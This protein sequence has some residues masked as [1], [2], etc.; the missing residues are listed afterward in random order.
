MRMIPARLRAA[1]RLKDVIDEAVTRAVNHHNNMLR[2]HL[3]DQYGVSSLFWHDGSVT[4]IQDTYVEVDW[5][6]YAR[7]CL[8]DKGVD[9]IP[10]EA[11]CDDTY[12]EAIRKIVADKLEKRG[13]DLAAK[14]AV[15]LRKKRA[16]LATLKA[17]LGEG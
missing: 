15:E 10:V 16:Q 11:L 13:I 1:A 6:E 7:S 8:V 3:K 5:D 2:P 9:R 4:G 12:D 17:E 14:E